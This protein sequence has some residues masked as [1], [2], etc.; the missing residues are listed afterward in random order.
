MLKSFAQLYWHNKQKQV[1]GT[2]NEASGYEAPYEVEKGA[3]PK[4]NC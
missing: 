4:R 3:K 2:Q 1:I